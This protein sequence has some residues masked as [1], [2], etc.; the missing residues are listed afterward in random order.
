MV[1]AASPDQAPDCAAK[2]LNYIKACREAIRFTDHP[3]S[4]KTL[5]TVPAIQPFVDRLR[6]RECMAILASFQVSLI[7]HP[8]W[9]VADELARWVRSGSLSLACLEI[10]VPG[11]LILF[12]SLFFITGGWVGFT[13]GCQNTQ[14]LPDCL[15]PRVLFGPGSANF[16]LV[17]SCFFCCISVTLA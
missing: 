10:Y 5:N 1:A 12:L 17:P 6:S 11:W 2:I 3:R 16:I 8:T 13:A 4:A 9:I 15:S 7:R 14:W